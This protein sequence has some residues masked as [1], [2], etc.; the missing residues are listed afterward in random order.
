M[1]TATYP[2]TQAPTAPPILQPN[3]SRFGRLRHPSQKARYTLP[4]LTVLVGFYTLSS[5]PLV[6][7][8]VFLDQSLDYILTT[9]DNI[10]PFAFVA[11]SDAADVMTYK[12]AMSHPDREDLIVAMRKELQDHQECGHWELISRT[13]IPRGNKVIPAIWSMCQKVDG[14]WRK[15]HKARQCAGGHQQEYGVNFFDTYSLG[16]QWMTVRLMLVLA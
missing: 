4:S 15:K 13:D 2:A 16:V 6:A 7:L 12:Q 8:Q 14:S 3:I 9:L 10:H 5:N 1:V 11:K